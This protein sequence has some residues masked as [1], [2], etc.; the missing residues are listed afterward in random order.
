M[1]G[2]LIR[3]RR[4]PGTISDRAA[5]LPDDLLV[6]GCAVRDERAMGRLFDRHAESVYRFLWKL[7]GAGADV[8]DLTHA[9]FLEAFRSAAHFRRGSQV[10]TWLFG[11]ALNVSRHYQ[12]SESRRRAFLRAWAVRGQSG[13]A[14]PD[15]L[16]EGRQ[17]VG[18]FEEALAA[19]KPDLR[20]VYL[21]CDVEELRGIEAAAA[22]GIR[23]GTLGRRLHEARK[24]LRAAVLGPA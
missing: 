15:R 7:C 3:F 22:L 2:K 16:A 18:R 13:S 20:A 21:L 19:L 14:L 1:I 5:D 4:P 11:I 12:R 23:P 24:A 8:E 10:R 6:S 9:T 17:L